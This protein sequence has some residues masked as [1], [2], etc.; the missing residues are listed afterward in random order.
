MTS[1]TSVREFNPTRKQNPTFF[2]KKQARRP[3]EGTR[4]QIGNHVVPRVRATGRRSGREEEPSGAQRWLVM[5]DDNGEDG[6]YKD[7]VPEVIPETNEFIRSIVEPL[8][9]VS[10][11]GP[12]RSGK[13]TLINLLAECKIVE[14][15]PTAGDPS[16]LRKV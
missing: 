5:I 11:M 12:T 1:P 9:L 10:I 3:R 4:V 13:S 16:R 15:F 14:L 8:N 2:R 7:L 6:E